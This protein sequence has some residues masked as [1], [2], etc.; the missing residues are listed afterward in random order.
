MSG[1]FGITAQ[2]A[3][4]RMPEQ[5][6]HKLVHHICFDMYGRCQTRAFLCKVCMN[7]LIVYMGELV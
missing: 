6:N 2:A 4:S 7:A 5:D 1:T 3:F